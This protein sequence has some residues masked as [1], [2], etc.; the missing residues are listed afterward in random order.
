M[1]SATVDGYEPIDVNYDW[2]WQGLRQTTGC[3]AGWLPHSLLSAAT[4]AV[5]QLLLCC[6]TSFCMTTELLTVTEQS[7]IGD[8]R[9]R[10]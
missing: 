9:R 1:T 8:M 7:T 5:L 4:A 2:A 6:D 3:G 10:H